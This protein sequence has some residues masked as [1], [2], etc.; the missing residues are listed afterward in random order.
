LRT[1]VIVAGILGAWLWLGIPGAS[2]QSGRAFVL[3]VNRANPVETV[4]A[5]ELRDM[6]LGTTSTWGSGRRVTVVLRE[7]GTE[8]RRMLGWAC[9]R[10]SEAEFDK[11]LLRSVFAGE[12]VGAPKTVNTSGAVKKFVFNVPGAIGIIDSADLDDTVKPITFQ[13][14][15]VGESGYQLVTK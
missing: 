1:E 2:A 7:R 4:T 10:L 8:E 6:V 12:S 11:T 15:R 14:R 5:A 9:C 13:G 3:I